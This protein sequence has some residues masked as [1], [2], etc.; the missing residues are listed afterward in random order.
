MKKKYKMKQ[1]GLAWYISDR[2][3]PSTV[4]ANT[5][6]YQIAKYAFYGHLTT[7]TI[8]S[9]YALLESAISGQISKSD[10]EKVQKTLIEVKSL[11]KILD[12]PDIDQ[13]DSY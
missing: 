4:I 13:T 2:G 1:H 3:T 6:D 10:H 7:S 11:I 5:F 12:S 9:L 8:K